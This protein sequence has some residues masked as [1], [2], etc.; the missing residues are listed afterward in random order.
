MRSEESFVLL[1]IS[2]WILNIFWIQ[3]VYLAS[4]LKKEEK[5]AKFGSFVLILFQKRAPPT[6]TESCLELVNILLES[7]TF[8]KSIFCCGSNQLVKRARE[9]LTISDMAWNRFMETQ[10]WNFVLEEDNIMIRILIRV[11][12]TCLLMKDFYY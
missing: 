4:K 9:I 1:P 10:L 8:N 5:A 12:V 2:F 3:V 11:R 6:H 7:L